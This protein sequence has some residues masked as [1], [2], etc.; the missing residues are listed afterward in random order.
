M[1][2]DSSAVEKFEATLSDGTVLQFTPEA[3][4]HVI[5][6]VQ[7]NDWDPLGNSV[8]GVR[9]SG[10]ILDGAYHCDNDGIQDCKIRID[11]LRVDV[12]DNIKS[13]LPLDD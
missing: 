11:L 13:A 12:L 1:R 9:V 6:G 5:K 3:Q 7:S 2:G 4:D 10:H 8:D